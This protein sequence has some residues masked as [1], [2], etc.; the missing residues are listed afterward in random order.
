[1][2]PL[3][4]LAIAMVVVIGGVLIFR[5]HAFL[6]LTVG[7]LLVAALTPTAA[8]YENEL[9]SAALKVQALAESESPEMF[10]VKGGAGDG[11][12]EGGRLLV[13][14]PEASQDGQPIATLEVVRV[15]QG[16]SVVRPVEPSEYEY[17]AGD[18]ILHPVSA[19]N[20]EKTSQLTIGDRVAVGFGTTC[21]NIGILIAMAAIIGKCLLDS[22]AAERVV[23]S[24]RRAVGDERTPL[25]LLLSA[26]VVGIPVFFDTVFYLMVPLGKALAARTGRNYLLYILAITSGGAI[27]H[28]LVPPT[29][30][31]LLV[32]SQLEVDLGL[33]MMAGC[34][35]GLLTAISGY[36]FAVWANRRW[37]IP[38]R[39]SA[40]LTDEQLA[41]MSNR[42]ETTL[43]PLWL[44]LLPILLPVVLIAGNTMYDVMF[45]AG[46]LPAMLVAQKSLV[47]TLGN[48]NI[49]LTLSAFIAIATLVWQKRTS[50]HKLAEALQSSLTSGGVIILITAAGGAFGLTLRQTGIAQEIGELIPIAQSGLILPLAFLITAVIRVAQGSATVAMITGVGIVAPLALAGSLP[51]HPVYLAIAIGC[52]S[53]PGPWMNDSGFWVISQMTGM[54]EKE[55]LKTF[56]VSMTMMGVVGLLFTMLAAYLVPLV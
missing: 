5:L 9:R 46:Q 25:A 50:W 33:M 49:A 18:L 12:I 43:P 29:P 24:T 11:L 40:E 6:A 21:L 10:A 56:T 1:M 27:A 53:K 16:D 30:G 39:P 47:D 36:L 7:A 2:S 51:F 42:D 22:G 54:T 38:L 41:E 44:S 20:A 31:P 52:G 17:Q 45:K 26:F 35:I 37:E 34:V 23:F 8:V 14:R 13:F 19:R 32:A 48:K 3:L 4:I 28:S 55:T 15:N